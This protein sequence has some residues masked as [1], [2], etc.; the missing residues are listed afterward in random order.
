MSSRRR[1]VVSSARSG[2]ATAAAALSGPVRTMLW[3]AIAPST[4]STALAVRAP[5]SM[6][7]TTIYAA[8]AGSR[9]SRAAPSA[10]A[11]SGCSGTATSIRSCSRSAWTTPTFLATPPV[12]TRS[13]SIPTRRPVAT[14]L[15]TSASWTPQR[16]SARAAPRW[17]SATISDSANT[18]Q[19]LVRTTDRDPERESPPIS[20]RGTSSISAT[21]SRNTPEPAAHLSL[22]AK[23]VR[24]PAASQRMTRVP[25]APTSMTVR[26]PGNH[27]CAPRAW[28]SIGVRWPSASATFSRPIPVAKMRWMLARSMPSRSSVCSKAQRATAPTSPAMTNVAWPRGPVSC[29]RTTATLSWPMSM[30]AVTIRDASSREP[31][32]RAR[33]ARPP[34]G[35]QARHAGAVIAPGGSADPAP[36]TAVCWGAMSGALSGVRVVDCSQMWAGPGTG[37]YLADHGADVIKV[38]PLTGDGARVTFTQAPVGGG[39]SRAFL[40]LNRGKRGLALGIRHPRPPPRPSG[41]WIADC[42]AP[43]ELAYGI[44][45]ALFERARTGR[46]RM[47]TTSLLHAALAMQSPDLV[48]VA[49]APPGDGPDYATQAMFAPYRCRDGH[50]L[51]LVVVQDDHQH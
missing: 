10:P 48:Q 14:I 17:I 50:Y 32:P 23:S 41:V 2:P 22:R 24:F 25:S 33:I 27:Q 36:A 42:S 43:M 18:A 8:P 35:S 1:A 37:M 46:G 26:V 38:E 31:R 19:V 51:L 29:R 34:G 16:M 40:P 11:I 7:H 4:S 44:A 49:T 9:A 39:E 3:A 15:A 20:A 28:L 12:R 47:V 30:P 13:G 5:T 45:L 6:P 21:D